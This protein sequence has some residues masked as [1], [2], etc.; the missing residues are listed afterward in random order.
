MI[1][2]AIYDDD[3]EQGLISDG[4]LAYRTGEAPPC[5]YWKH[6]LNEQ[7]WTCL[8]ISTKC[9]LASSQRSNEWLTPS[10]S[11]VVSHSSLGNRVMGYIQSFSSNRAFRV[12]TKRKYSD[13]AKG[14]LGCSQNAMLERFF[15]SFGILYTNS[16]TYILPLL[17]PLCSRWRNKCRGSIKMMAACCCKKP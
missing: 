3:K 11:I 14:I 12:R 5:S 17:V 13:T 4:Q 9:I 10:S 1:R 2:T 15:F 7:S 6:K 8:S 16:I